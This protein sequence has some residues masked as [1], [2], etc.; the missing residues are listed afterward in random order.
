MRHYPSVSHSPVP[1]L[2]LP[3]IR[4]RLKYELQRQTRSVTTRRLEIS[5]RVGDSQQLVFGDTQDPNVLWELLERRVWS[6]AGGVSQL[7]IATDGETSHG[8]LAPSTQQV[9][10]SSLKG[11]GSAE[12]SVI[13]PTT[14]VVRK[15]TS[16]ADAL[17]ARRR[18]RSA[19]GR[20]PTSR[21]T[22]SR[23]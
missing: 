3:C 13:L 4:I 1:K 23:L 7:T 6:E 11:K 17:T 5:F 15:I 2:C 21:T 12:I 22:S 10:L 18:M 19:M 14:D 8:S 9:P 16:S 20:G